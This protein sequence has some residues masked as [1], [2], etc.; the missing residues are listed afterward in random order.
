MPLPPTTNYGM[1]SAT[2]RNLMVGRG[3]NRK[4]TEW[5]MVKKLLQK[6]GL[7]QGAHGTHRAMCNY[8]FNHPQS[9][10]GSLGNEAGYGPNFE[11]AYNG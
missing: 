1:T 10:S 4:A 7:C 9:F 2:I 8:N 6:P 3:H 11:Q 5:A